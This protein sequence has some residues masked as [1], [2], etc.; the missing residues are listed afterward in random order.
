MHVFLAADHRGFHLQQ[1]L[2]HWLMAQ[3]YQVTNLG[4]AEPDPTDDYP[5]ISFALAEQLLAGPSPSRGILLCGSG[6]GA[7]VAANKVAGIRCGLGMMVDQVVAGR[8]DDDMNVLALAA[9]YIT[10]E[11]AQE[12]T[13]AFLHTPFSQADRHQRRLDQIRRKENG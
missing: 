5:L 12:L 6:V 13:D 9:D 8:R 11:Q 10:P 3:G 4:P 1:Q 2:Y 7:C